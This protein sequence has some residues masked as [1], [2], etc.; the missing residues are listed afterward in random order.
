MGGRAEGV[1]VRQ[2]RTE[3]G[4]GVDQGGVTSGVLC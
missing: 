3:A 4:R 2:M 1:K